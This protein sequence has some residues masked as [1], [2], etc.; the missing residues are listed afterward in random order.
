MN[1]L[2]EFVVSLV[3]LLIFITAIELVGPDNSMKKYLKFV[4][5]LILLAVILNPIISFFNNGEEYLIN[6]IDAYSDKITNN[7]IDDTKEEKMS[8]DKI[9]E[10]NFKENF[11]KNCESTLNKK[12]E[13][14]TFEC[15]VDCNVNFNDV[16]MKVNSLK[17]YA[18]S[19][20]VRK[21]EKITVGENEHTDDENKRKIKEFLSEELKIRK[22][23]IEVNYK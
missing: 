18:K 21:V 7:E 17:I 3:T 16:E 8:N 20:G 11:N 15:D 12:F 22:D 9:R 4:L 14:F 2:K 13:E 5:G 23:K 10:E 19:K 6:A 1:L